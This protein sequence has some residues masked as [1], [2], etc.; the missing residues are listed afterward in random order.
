ML[1]TVYYMHII[2]WRTWQTNVHAPIYVFVRS[3][4]SPSGNLFPSARH[5]SE[6][7]IRSE[8]P[9]LSAMRPIAIVVCLRVCIIIIRTNMR[10]A[11]SNMYTSIRDPHDFSELLSVEFIHKRL[12]RAKT[13]HSQPHRCLIHDHL[14]DMTNRASTMQM[15]Y[16]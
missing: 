16:L 12:Q 5:V 2:R 9:R 10:E 1:D 11:S 8:N 14:T 4:A 15:R 7:R 6:N 3:L 13:I